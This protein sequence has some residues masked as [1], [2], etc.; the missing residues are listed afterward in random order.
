MGIAG[1]LL[2]AACMAVSF[3]IVNGVEKLIKRLK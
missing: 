1:T 3:A 2:F